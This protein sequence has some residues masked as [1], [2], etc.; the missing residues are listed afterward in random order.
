MPTHT[1]RGSPNLC[2]RALQHKVEEMRRRVGNKQQHLC[3]V[4]E[5]VSAVDTTQTMIICKVVVG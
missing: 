3:M 1:W 2:Y 4:D 5:P